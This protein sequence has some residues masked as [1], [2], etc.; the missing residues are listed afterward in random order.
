[1]ISD[2]SVVHKYVIYYLAFQHAVILGQDL[3]VDL[4]KLIG[5]TLYK[6]IQWNKYSKQLHGYVINYNNL[7]W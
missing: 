5:Y 7:A 3:K 6:Y 1:M 4:F 2:T